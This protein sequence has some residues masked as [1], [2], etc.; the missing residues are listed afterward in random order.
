LS[1]E[2]RLE[3][4]RLVQWVLENFPAPHGGAAVRAEADYYGAK[5]SAAEIF[6]RYAEHR[7]RT[8]EAQVER[9]L[10]DG[11][12]A[13]RPVE[14]RGA[15]SSRAESV[16]VEKPF[17]RTPEEG[18]ERRIDSGAQLMVPPSAEVL[19]GK[20]R[21]VVA[22]EDV[23]DPSIHVPLS[24]WEDDEEESGVQRR[25][26]ALVLSVIVA[27]GILVG[28]LM[29]QVH[30]V[31]GWRN[32]RGSI[33]DRLDALTHKNRSALD[34]P[35]DL[36]V[37]PPR[38]P[39]EPPPAPV[40]RVVRPP[41]TRAAA[42]PPMSRERTGMDRPLV[43]V[44]PAPSD[45]IDPVPGASAGVAYDTVLRTGGTGSG[46]G[47]AASVPGNGPISVPGGVMEGNLLVSRTPVYPEGARDGRV[48]LQAIISKNGSVGHLRVLSGD[49][50]LRGPAADA[51]AKWRY[52]PYLV[53]NEPAEVS[54]IVTV[55]FKRSQ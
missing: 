2:E 53:N 13:E 4:L 19:P 27:G 31:E 16:W 45:R 38:T 29:A 39:V 48:V 32:L 5:L 52:R 54:T 43:R 9:A 37:D 21:D 1:D 24:D 36:V 12:L 25:A 51:V 15:E 7:S 23:D 30:V 11:R 3:R 18:A 26:F 35:N 41:E 42:S 40:R 33:S 10:A 22:V 49:P 28:L 34:I 6:A 46:G 14:E 8:P 44:L 20:A 17:W 47:V 55:D 50:V